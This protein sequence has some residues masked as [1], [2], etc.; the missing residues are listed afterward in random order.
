[1]VYSEEF[2]SIADARVREHQLKRWSAQKMAALISGDL[3][4]LHLLAKRRC[5]KKR[6]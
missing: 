3:G 5:Q 4:R 1:L 2:V 6:I